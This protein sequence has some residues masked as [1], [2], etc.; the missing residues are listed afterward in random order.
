M[1]F[2]LDKL[3]CGMINLNA[4]FMLGKLENITTLYTCFWD[5]PEN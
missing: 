5:Y 4:K 2:T 1:K 3:S